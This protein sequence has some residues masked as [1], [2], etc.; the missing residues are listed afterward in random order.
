MAIVAMMMMMM[1]MMA[2]CWNVVGI[3]LNEKVKS[4]EKR[5]LEKK[6]SAKERQGLNSH[7]ALVCAR[8]ISPTVVF[9]R[10]NLSV[11][12]TH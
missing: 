2:A 5:S 6:R 7:G 12:V 11:V 8:L 1:M 10:C 4:N 9:K 3:M